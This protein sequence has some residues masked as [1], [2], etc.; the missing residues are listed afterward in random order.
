MAKRE[1]DRAAAGPAALAF[2]G[3][4]SPR[5]GPAC[6]RFHFPTSATY[7][8]R[9]GRR[10]CDPVSFSP[11]S[12]CENV[13]GGGRCATAFR[14]L[15]ACRESLP[16]HRCLFFLCTHICLTRACAHGAPVNFALPAAAAHICGPSFRS[17]FPP[18]HFTRKAN[19]RP[20]SVVPLFPHSRAASFRSLEARRCRHFSRRAIDAHLAAG[21]AAACEALFG[22]VSRCLGRVSFSFFRLAGVLRSP[23]PRR[24]GERRPPASIGVRRRQLWQS[25]FGSPL[26]SCRFL[27]AHSR[28]GSFIAEAS[29]GVCFS[30]G[31]C[32]NLLPCGFRDRGARPPSPLP[33][34]APLSCSSDTRGRRR[35]EK[36]RC[37]VKPRDSRSVGIRHLGN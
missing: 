13:T 32:R 17:L 36:R 5:K 18:S 24:G 28:V 16:S 9:G 12:S 37:V 31:L 2:P 33:F 8:A 34:A 3:V 20:W 35:L 1:P 6:A 15:L 27:Y 7:F 19:F 25:S 30:L 26:F 4:A 23:P 11:V 14:V 21:A 22:S 29:V 10:G